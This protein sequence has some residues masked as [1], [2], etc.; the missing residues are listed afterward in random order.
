[1][2]PWTRRWLPLGAAWLVLTLVLL[3]AW[4][5]AFRP[6]A[7][8]EFPGWFLRIAGSTGS[9]VYDD[10]PL[11]LRVQIT[12]LILI[13]TAAAGAAIAI[14][15]RRRLV[16]AIGEL[17]NQKRDP[18]DL[19][20][21][22]IVVFW[23]IY[24]LAAI[25][26]IV[27]Y[28]SL[29]AG[30]QFPPETALPRWGPLAAW[31]HWPLHTVSPRA[32]A[33]GLGIM[34]GAAVTAALGF[35]S[36]TSAAIVALLFLLAWGRLQWYGKVDHQHHLFWFA[37]LLAL[38]PCGDAL[39]LDALAA[40][41]R[42][43][44]SRNAGPAGP[45]PRYGRPLAFA[46]ILMG[47]IYLFPG[48]WKACRSGLDWAL[49]DNP[50]L[51]MQRDWRLAGDWQPLLRFDEYPI[52]YRA[53]ALGALLFE[54]TF[55]FLL[56]GRKTR[57][58]AGVLGFGFHLVTYLTLNIPFTTLRN[59][60]VV[61]VDWRGL[62][63]RV[64]YRGHPPAMPPAREEVRPGRAPYE[65]LPLA[66]AMVGTLLVGG[67]LWAGAI[68]AMDGWPLACYPPFDGLTEPYVRTLRL[69]VTLDDG[70]QRVVDPDDY[71]ATIRGQWSNILQRNLGTR[72]EERERR[73]PL[74]WQVIGRTEAWA[75]D[76][77]HVRFY[78][79][80]RPVDRAHWGEEPD[81]PLLLYETSIEP[82]GP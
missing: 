55:L 65:T 59:S 37:M 4:H 57:P 68:R 66:T 77:R 25:D 61:F 48:L 50:R 73:L 28:A 32:I 9:V 11:V 72:P 20:V 8:Q 6:T 49:T 23:Q 82:H 52:L 40:R 54:L 34:K 22:R 74:V 60:Y 2:L 36:R 79:V 1:M 27:G 43:E 58:V 39:S 13:A 64:R 67:N 5:A 15:E 19:A 41:L 33:V 12:R 47:V 62:L 31:A 80:R 51:L 63:R 42:R 29:P 16:R 24:H 53:G 14:G 21:F 75:A 46:M 35:F 76:A 7:V 56:L 70:S 30:L 18:L 78:S 3:A 38:A 71:R 44:R 69:T 26:L 45:S 10:P 17:V 81:D